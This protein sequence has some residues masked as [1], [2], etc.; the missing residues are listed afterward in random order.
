[1]FIS[2]DAQSLI[3][4][5][6]K[7]VTV[8]R[9]RILQDVLDLYEDGDIMNKRLV[10]TFDGE[11]GMDAGGVLKDMYTQFWA[12]FIDKYTDG[13]DIV[14]IKQ[15]PTIS[16]EVRALAPK[17]GTILIHQLLECSELPRKLGV[18]FLLQCFYPDYVCNN[19]IVKQDMLK[20]FTIEERAAFIQA[21]Q[22][23]M[24][25]STSDHLLNIFSNFGM[26][27]LPTC[28]NVE[29]SLVQIGNHV[30]VMNQRYVTQQINESVPD[31]VKL[32]VF[33]MSSPLDFVDYLESLKPTATD[34]AG[35]LEAYQYEHLTDRRKEVLQ[36]LKSIVSSFTTSEVDKFLI[37]VTASTSLPQSL[38]VHFFLAE[39]EMMLPRG[40]TCG[41]VIEVALGYDS[42][43]ELRHY[44][45]SALNDMKAFEMTMA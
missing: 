25:Q 43:A 13:N 7:E 18:V 35:L 16:Y 28:H 36:W 1:M 21:M 33:S 31:L 19:N 27:Q 24:S 41:N 6:T 14:Y 3:L 11:M 20:C 40:R 5:D 29:N 26:T 44:L 8:N 22:G 4:G 12:A 38:V 15:S 42:R 23:Q 2:D 9:Q 30:L 17:L 45:M 39:G 10:V 37:F 34:V 32:Q